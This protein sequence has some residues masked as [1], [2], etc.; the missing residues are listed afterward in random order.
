MNIDHIFTYCMLFAGT[1]AKQ[2]GKFDDVE[3]TKR[4][5]YAVYETVKKLEGK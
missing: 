5:A 2:Q 4:L 1:L 3:Y